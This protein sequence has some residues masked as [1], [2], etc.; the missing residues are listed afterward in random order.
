ME[1]IIGGIIGDIIKI[2]NFTQATKQLPL[3]DLLKPNPFSELA[4]DLLS[5]I[6]SIYT[7]YHP[8]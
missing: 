8:L 3:L 2:L 4:P 7:K 1:I 6:Q 5:I